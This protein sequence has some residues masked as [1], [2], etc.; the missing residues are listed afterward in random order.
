[1]L[2]YMNYKL[3]DEDRPCSSKSAHLHRRSNLQ[4]A[5]TPHTKPTAKVGSD[6]CRLIYK[7]NY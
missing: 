7:Y 5:T 4:N 2:C 3:N 6:A 1:M